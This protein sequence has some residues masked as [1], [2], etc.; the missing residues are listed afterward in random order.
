MFEHVLTIGGSFFGTWL[1][2]QL[3]FNRFS[4][5]KVWERKAAAYT[6]IFE[7]M[8]TIWKWCDKY[9]EAAILSR[10]LDV[11]T[12]DRLHAEMKEAKEKLALRLAGE[13][14]LIPPLPRS[15]RQD[16]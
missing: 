7:V 11:P 14:W 6:A 10:D 16:G 9:L 13:I 15:V 1:A 12:V 5:E 2:A 3:A 4:R 8:H